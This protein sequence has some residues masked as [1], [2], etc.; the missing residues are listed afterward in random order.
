[1]VAV[2]NQGKYLANVRLSLELPL[3]IS[4]ARNC[5]KPPFRIPPT[6]SS[7]KLPDPPGKLF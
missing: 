1:M 3:D 4:R 7:F 2:P 5:A 6:V